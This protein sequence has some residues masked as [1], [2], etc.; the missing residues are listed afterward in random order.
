MFNKNLFFL[1]SFFIAS[2]IFAQ[3]FKFNFLPNE[4][5]FMPLKANHLEAKMGILYYPDNGHLKVDIGN[6]MDLLS[7]CFSDDMKINVGIDFFAYA[8]STNYAGRRLQIDA[9]DGFFGGHAS[10]EKRYNDNERFL[11]RFRIVHNSAHFVDGHWIPETNSWIKDVKPIPFTQDFGEF[12][13]AYEKRY[14]SMVVMPYA[15]IGYS[16]LV[17][18][19]LIEKYWFTAGAEISTNKIFGKAFEKETNLFFAGHFKYSGMPD[20]KGSIN[21]MLGVKFGDWFDEGIIFYTSYYYGY[22]MFSEYYYRRNAKF[23]IGFQ[24]DFI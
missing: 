23:A 8:L 1:I 16:T 22:N 21:T 18:P 9:L 15:G 6:S 4:M 2:Q 7:F 17:R 12:T 5:V 24:V 11:T 10:F 20:Y 19:S 14:N 13:F 3:N